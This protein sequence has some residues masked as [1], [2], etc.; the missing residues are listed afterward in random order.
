MRGERS[1]DNGPSAKTDPASRTHLDDDLHRG[2]TRLGRVLKTRVEG[3]VCE[4]EGT[5]CINETKINNGERRSYRQTEVS[6]WVDNREEIGFGFSIFSVTFVAG[7]DNLCLQQGLA[8]VVNRSFSCFC[9]QI[10]LIVPMFCDFVRL[11]CTVVGT[12][13][14]SRKSFD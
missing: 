2:R 9:W 3:L 13:S 8:L 7:T 6:L 1:R 10:F 11:T 4:R 14:S 5:L 12:V